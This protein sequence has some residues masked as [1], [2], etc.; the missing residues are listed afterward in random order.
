MAWEPAEKVQKNEAGEYRALIG[1]A[2]IP[3]KSAQKSDTG[4]YQV[5]RGEVPQSN[6]SAAMQAGRKADISIGGFPIGS[7]VQGFINAMQGPTF[8]FADEIAGAVAAPF[9]KYQQTRD[10]VRGATEQ[11]RQERP[12]TAGVTSMMTAAPTMLIPGFGGGQAATAIGVGGKALQAT[13]VGAGQGAVSGLGESTSQDI[14]GMVFDTAKGG[15]LGGGFGAGGQGV[16]SGVGA[17]GGNIAQR[18]LPSEIDNKIL[19]AVTGGSSADA[20]R[21]KLAEALARGV[22]EGSVFA[23]P[24]SA[25]TPAGRASAR[26]DRYGPGATIA[27]VGGQS[28]KQLLDILATLPGKSKGAVEELIHIRQAGRGG[29]IVTAAD[30]AL[31]TQGKGY[32]AT[33]EAL[34]TA[35]KSASKPFYDKLKDLTVKVDDDLQSLLKASDMAHGGAE[36]RAQLRQEVNIDLSKLKIG[37][38]VPFSALDKIKQSLY[39]MGQVAKR[40]GDPIA[41][42]FGLLRIN[43]TKKLDDL[44]PKDKVGSIY[45]Q[46]RD[47]YAGPAQLNDAVTAGRDV[48]KQNALS[49]AEITKEMTGGELE[50][51][52]IGAL[53]SIREKAGTEAGQTSILKMWKEPATSDKLRE[54]FG[55]NYRKFSVDV[56]KEARLKALEQVGRGSP[57]TGRLYAAGDL[58]ATAAVD[59]AQAIASATSGNV[60]PAIGGAA[61]VWNQVKMPED[62]RNQLARMLMLKGPAAQVELRD[63]DALIRMLNKRA[64]SQAASIGVLSGQSVNK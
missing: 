31:G 45:K 15:A 3:V 55:N 58:D 25:S 7:S 39:G 32:T 18:V 59:A 36:L 50:A 16:V 11:F 56:A 52:R 60:L 49:V 44:S 8:G 27:D 29:R 46:A 48:M 61:K 64:E 51:F 34:D 5:D 12:W 28:P 14:G 53:Q 35:K 21:V 2:W 54:I 26:L 20:A 19:R 6:E 22:P 43:L 62:T 38:T 13:K 63:V 33:L 41:S 9:G 24:G 17:V 4:A 23:Q 30:A 37:D 42:D 1:G 57:S 47:A 10:Y 40:Q